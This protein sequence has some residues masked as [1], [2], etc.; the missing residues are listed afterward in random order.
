MGNNAVFKLYSTD[1][2][3][4]ALNPFQIPL[5]ISKIFIS[6]AGT[7]ALSS[8]HIVQQLF[9]GTEF[10]L[11]LLLLSL[12]GPFASAQQEASCSVCVCYVCIVYKL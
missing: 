4:Y 2:I 7:H 9:H 3:I 5:H 10:I 1:E 8:A 6:T 11:L 12:N